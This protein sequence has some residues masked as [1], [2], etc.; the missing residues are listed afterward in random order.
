LQ[1]IVADV[2]ERHAEILKLERQVLE[3]LELFR[4]LSM[5]VDQQV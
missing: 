1:D 4:D 5:L 2:E 3:L